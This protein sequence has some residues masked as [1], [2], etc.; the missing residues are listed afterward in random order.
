MKRLL[1]VI[2]RFKC[3]IFSTVNLPY[4][5]LFAIIPLRGRVAQLGEH[6]ARIQEVRGSNPLTSTRVRVF[7]SNSSLKTFII[8]AVYK[9]NGG[10]IMKKSK[11]KHPLYFALAGVLLLAV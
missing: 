10:Y 1:K 8:K 9:P 3:A 11:R 4:K 2:A 5:M 6:L 7:G